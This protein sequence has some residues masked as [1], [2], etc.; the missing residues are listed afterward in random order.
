MEVVSF[1]R[2]GFDIGYGNFSQNL[3]GNGH[4]FIFSSGEVNAKVPEGFQCS[5]GKTLVHWTR[6]DYCGQDKLTYLPNNLGEEGVA[7]H[8][9]F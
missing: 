6:C 7:K 1:E 4:T 5:C 2:N 3:C 8:Y 9:E